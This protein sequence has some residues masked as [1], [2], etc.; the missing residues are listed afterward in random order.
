MGQSSSASWLKAGYPSVFTIGASA[1]DTSISLGPRSRRL[2]AACFATLIAFTCSQRALSKRRTIRIY[3]LRTSELTPTIIRSR[4]SCADTGA[5]SPFPQPY[6]Y[7]GRV[8]LRAHARVLQARDCIRRRA[9]RVVEV[10]LGYMVALCVC[11]VLSICSRCRVCL[12]LC[13][14]R[15]ICITCSGPEMSR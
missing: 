12:D 11:T 6:G 9:W 15:P 13:H 4:C 3:T 2:L 10:L 8:Q 14:V 5:H 1:I 7:F